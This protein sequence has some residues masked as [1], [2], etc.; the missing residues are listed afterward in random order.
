MNR[1]ITIS[2]EFGSGGREVGRRLSEI[3]GFA[4]YDQEIVAEIAKRT[5]LSE[6]YVR[7][8]AEHRPLVPFPIHVGRTFHP[9][10]D[11]LFE[12]TLAVYQEQSRIIKEMAD[13]SDCII[14]GRCGDYILR[15]QKPLRVFVY[16]DMEHRLQRCRERAPEGENLSD[17]E[18]KQQILD[19]DKRR[20][21][22]YE[23]Y[24]GKKWGDRLNYD[25]CVNTSQWSIE[26]IA[27]AIA[28]IFKVGPSGESDQ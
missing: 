13:Q 6:R 15:D 28:Q 20:A 24:S 18:L 3:L 4:Y 2:R 11:P 8:V 5:S 14:V 27:G 7:T 19:I 10:M 1:I 21:R 22:Y 23:N 17:K 9:V 26:E 12:Q 16:S 25:L